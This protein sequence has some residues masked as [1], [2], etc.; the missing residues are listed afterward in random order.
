MNYGEFQDYIKDNL[1]KYL[2]VT[3]QEAKVKYISYLKEGK[4]YDRMVVTRDTPNGIGISPAIPL[5]PIYMMLREGTS[6]DLVMKILAED[7]LYGDEHRKARVRLD[8]SRENVLKN[9]CTAAVNHEMA[10]LNNIPYLQV[11]DLAIIAKCRIAG[12]GYLTIT[13]ALAS[14]LGMDG[15]AIVTLAIENNVKAAPPVLQSM[16]HRFY[17]NKPGMRVDELIPG[18]LPYSNSL[19]SLSNRERT[20]GASYIANKGVLHKIALAMDS[21]LIIAPGTIHELIVFPKGVVSDVGLIKNVVMGG[22]EKLQDSDDFL[23]DN[24]Y[25]YDAAAK[26]LDMYDN[27]LKKEFVQARQKPA[28]PRL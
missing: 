22:R 15:D 18:M 25:V 5:A 21:D 20:F 8:L 2:P 4:Q 3:Y 16:E 14:E 11:N 7:Y 1:T 10:D 24:V 19:W 27:Q 23:S 13:D 9:L 6:L 17:S 12:N 26:K 28:A